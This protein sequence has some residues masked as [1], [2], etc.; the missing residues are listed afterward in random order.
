MS[1]SINNAVTN[2]R[3][4]WT[5]PVDAGTL[6]FCI[7]AWVYV[8]DRTLTDQ[9]LFS[10]KSTASAI[11]LMCGITNQVPFFYRETTTTGLFYAGVQGTATITA[12]A[13]WYHVVM[14]H[15]GD[16]A[17]GTTSWKIWVN[18][19][20]VSLTDVGNNSGTL[21]SL[22]GGT[23]DWGNASDLGASTA[24][25]GRVRDTAVWTHTQGTDIL[26]QAE[27]TSLYA[28]GAGM[29]P[30]FLTPASGATL[31]HAPSF[32]NAA[33]GASRFD[34][35]I[36]ALGTLDGAPVGPSTP[37]AHTPSATGGASYFST[38]VDVTN[39]MAVFDCRK[40]VDATTAGRAINWYDLSGHGEVLHDDNVT[41]ATKPGYINSGSDVFVCCDAP[42]SSGTRFTTNAPSTFSNG[43]FACS[44]IMAKNGTNDGARL[45]EATTANNLTIKTNSSGFLQVRMNSTDHTCTKARPSSN[46]CEVGI[47][48]SQT[49]SSSAKTILVF[50]DGNYVETLTT[51]AFAEVTTNRLGLFGPSSSL[52][53]TTTGNYQ[54]WK[55]ILWY[56]AAKTQ[57]EMETLTRAQCAEFSVP[58]TRNGTV[59][60][61]GSSSMHASP[62]TTFNRDWPYLCNWGRARVFNVARINTRLATHAFAVSTSTG[63]ANAVA[64]DDGETITQ[65]GTGDTFQFV[66]ESGNLVFCNLLTG[67]GVDAAQNLNG[68]TAIRD[69][70]SSSIS[71]NGGQTQ[72]AFLT[73][74]D[75]IIQDTNY[76]GP[77]LL[78]WQVGANDV[79]GGV[80]ATAVANAYLAV[81][82]LRP[83]PGGGR[84]LYHIPV[85]PHPRVSG[86][87]LAT[88]VSV[89]RT[90][91][92]AGSVSRFADYTVNTA[93]DD[94]AT[95][96]DYGNATYYNA[97]TIHLNITGYRTAAPYITASAGSYLAIGGGVAS[98]LPAL[99]DII[100][101]E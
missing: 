42:A 82:A 55:Q 88:V 22:S 40:W 30:K 28:G 101:S 25:R 75:A 46:M 69:P 79:P 13:T 3:V 26:T 9:R 48:V 77:V 17:A 70:S 5:A 53:S 81:K 72:A 92:T 84:T 63:D 51:A 90:A 96:S 59:I 10:I 87:N 66:A 49:N 32:A 18:G 80:D 44:F 85:S 23:F 29:P 76:A 45:M 4:R 93:F 91:L 6:A 95:S 94:F 56:S 74:I 15:R 7:S 57:G 34:S 38:P 19:A 31:R 50:I 27:V 41:T 33:G 73:P 89:L 12:N 83:S 2:Q 35:V 86:A 52:G 36:D 39:I 37:D 47:S 64:F 78:Y 100:E 61:H 54:I 11:G 24:F 97:D 65:T 67:T 14:Q 20:A 62:Y 1:L 68:A 71:T 16:G 8:N 43:N 98:Y 60:L 21:L 58:T 99:M